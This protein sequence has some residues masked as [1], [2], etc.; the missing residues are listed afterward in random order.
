M[1]RIIDVGRSSS[2]SAERVMNASRCRTHENIDKLAA[3]RGRVAEG[4]YLT[5]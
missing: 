3:P 2:T 5:G 4:S 1:P